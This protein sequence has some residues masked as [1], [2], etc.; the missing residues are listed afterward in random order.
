MSRELSMLAVVASA[1]EKIGA[2]MAKGL[3]SRLRAVDCLLLAPGR[4]RDFR[5]VGGL[6][7]RPAAGIGK[8]ALLGGGSRE[9][10]GR[11]P[12]KRVRRECGFNR[13][14]KHQP[15]QIFNGA[16]RTRFVPRTAKRRWQLSGRIGP[17]DDA[18]N[19]YPR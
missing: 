9:R 6:T 17:L 14:R 1:F 13:D 12:D 8:R 16:R 15:C 11:R 5:S 18:S 4:G 3:G 7:Q 19:Y 2:T 10:E